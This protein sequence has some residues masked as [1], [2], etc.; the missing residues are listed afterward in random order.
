[1]RKNI[2]EHYGDTT[3]IM[4]AQRISTI[5]HCDKILVMDEGRIVGRGTHS[6]LLKTC[7]VYYEIASSQLTKEELS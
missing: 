2:R 5:L 7:P 1:M 3:L 6:E 4:V